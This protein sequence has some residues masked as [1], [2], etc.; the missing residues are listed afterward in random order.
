MRS[1]GKKR[2][3]KFL[4]ISVFVIMIAA[5]SAVC[6][7]GCGE[8]RYDHY[9]LTTSTNSDGTLTITAC[10]VV[11]DKDVV[12][13]AEYKG[14][15]ITTLGDGSKNV[16]GGCEFST[17]RIEAGVKVINDN[18]CK[19]WSPLVTLELNE[20]LERIGANA[21]SGCTALKDITVP[22][23]VTSIGEGAFEDTAWYKNQPNGKIIYVG[24]FLYEYKGNMPA[25]TTVNDIAA[26]TKYISDYAFSD[27]LGLKAV[28]LPEGLEKIGAY[29]FSGCTSLEAIDIPDSVNSVGSDAFAG[30]T[31]LTTVVIPSGIGTIAP[32][33]FYD[34]CDL[35]TVTVKSG[36][37]AVGESAFENCVALTTI[38]FPDSVAGFGKNAFKN[39]VNL[40]DV[41]ATA[42]EEYGE[43]VFDNCIELNAIALSTSTKTIG[44]NAFDN[45]VKITEVKLPATVA[46]VGASAFNNCIG[47]NK[48]TVERNAGENGK[49]SFG[50]KAFNNC[51]GLSG[52]YVNDIGAWCGIQ[53]ADAVANPLYQTGKL[54]VN[55]V[56]ITELVLPKTVT[57]IGAYS[58]VN[59]G[60][61]KVT[62][63]K[64]LKE[65]GVGAFKGCLHIAGVHAENMD[66]WC[67]VS[68]GDAEANPLY[69]G[70]KLYEGETEKTKIAISD[71]VKKIGAYAF[72]N[73][74]GL[75]EISIP[76]SV[77]EVGAN[78]FTGCAKLAKITYALEEQPE[79]W[80]ADWNDFCGTDV[81]GGTAFVFEKEK[82]YKPDTNTI[83]AIVVGGILVTVVLVLL[84]IWL[85]KKIK[86]KIKGGK[87]QAPVE[88]KKSEEEKPVEEP[89]TEET[90]TTPSEEE[91]TEE[92][93]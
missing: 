76:S 30:C 69:Y 3:I 15:K 77:E 62:I 65:V 8:I 74:T 72:Y 26:G 82:G 17:L 23:S 88:E 44:A 80:D 68:F 60:L 35:N 27:C 18:A 54:Y 41:T 6:L 78:A 43:G 61:Q 40:T 38:A 89:A 66:N 73:C 59:V 19:N 34:C 22:K 53:F 36:I 24:S 49:L 31:N 64:D 11:K 85:V 21:F 39:C 57:E 7:T 12:I 13:P 45:C 28:T 10:T 92:E 29:S 5:L 52:V 37:T 4:V 90:P 50:E 67:A 84:F 71:G 1:A 51:F 86:K 63:H 55:D 58:F 75:T 56:E 91:P 81:E 16:F 47:L 83:M 2:F 42:V 32:F 93:K 14:K 70:E 33:M 79:D 25:N 48:V 87:E 20:G 9:V 46:E